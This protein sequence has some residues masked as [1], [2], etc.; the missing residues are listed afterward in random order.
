MT[1]QLNRIKLVKKAEGGRRGVVGIEGGG[2]RTAAIYYDF[3]K[4]R[5]AEFSAGNVRLLSR[6]RLEALYREIYKKFGTAAVVVA[7]MAGA[8]NRGDFQKIEKVLR[9]FWK[10]SI[11]I[12]TN[13]LETALNSV[14]GWDEKKARILVIA[15]TGSCVYGKRADG[16]TVKVGGWGH[17]LGDSGSG[18]RVGMRAIQ[19]CLSCYDASGRFP[20]LGSRLLRKL[21]L[22]EPDDF[23]EW[24]QKATKSDVAALAAEVFEAA[25][26]G[27]KLAKKTIS[28]V[29]NNLVQD[30]LICARRLLK[31]GEKPCFILAGGLFKNQPSF[32]RDFSTRIKLFYPGSEF[33]VL[34]EGGAI[35]AVRI[36]IEY[37]NKKEMGRDIAG[38]K[39]RGALLN[40]G[41]EVAEEWY[42]NIP[43]S[44][45]LSPTE[46]ISPS[47]PRLD[48]VPL[49]EAVELF[50]AEDSKIAGAIKP[51]SG[52]IVRAI[53]MVVGAF[54]AGGRLIYVGA[55]TSGRLG[56]L[57]SS[58]C[59]PTFGVSAEQVQAI[60]AGGARAVWE[61]VE[62]AEDDYLAGARAVEF[63]NVG[64]RDIVFG[65]AA[66]GRTP[67]VWGAL[68][69]AKA[70]GAKTIL[71]CF[72]PYI[73]IPFQ[74]RP[75]LAIIIETGPELLAGSTR[76]KAGTATKMILNII[77]T[78]AMARIGRVKGNLMTDMRPS[79]TKLRERAIRIVSQA[80]VVNATVAKGLLE[81]SRWDIKKAIQMAR[82]EPR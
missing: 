48:K 9:R 71:L 53:K 28:E 41:F 31:K 6:A 67:F 17:I 39:G 55:G 7:G 54:K 10:D 30:A 56:V 24:V 72:N 13:D 59:P 2:T 60:I 1:K 82:L 11:C 77:S 23:I 21:M 5:R 35:G 78:V 8:R 19:N 25:R 45:N 14:E 58:E 73:K 29:L 42:K 49:K 36:G 4:I 51:H 37:L 79:N 63:R 16:K 15:G 70:R 3:E 80:A 38:F 22:N 65:I 20:S 26:G 76:L 18:Y 52:E 43:T 75:T 33:T 27:D 74:S 34:K 69:A 47:A 61:S 12:A 81:K 57:D 44:I 64:R 32:V 40:E 68:N 46:Q 62:G 50:L 66:S